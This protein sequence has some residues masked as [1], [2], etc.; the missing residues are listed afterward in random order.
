MIYLKVLGAPNSDG[1][2]RLRSR[3]YVSIR[4][5]HAVVVIIGESLRVP[6][7]SPQIR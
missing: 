1:D 2:D 7:F 3:P 6:P 5:V 4:N